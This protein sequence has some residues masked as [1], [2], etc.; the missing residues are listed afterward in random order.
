MS[1]FILLSVQK[2]PTCLTSL[3]LAPHSFINA[4]VQCTAFSR[5]LRAS[6]LHTLVSVRFVSTSAFCIDT[7][8]GLLLVQEPAMQS[9]STR[10]TSFMYGLM[11]GSS[12]LLGFDAAAHLC[13]ETLNMMRAARWSF[14]L[15]T[16]SSSLSGL[17]FLLATCACVTVRSDHHRSI[18][19]QRD[20]VICPCV[21]LCCLDVACDLPSRSQASRGYS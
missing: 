20:C 2:C 10:A 9:G 5:Q 13:E 18:R 8:T 7:P 11:A 16:V 1:Q 19:L 15:A 6:L 4:H 3:R 12:S 21:S 17:C 14:L